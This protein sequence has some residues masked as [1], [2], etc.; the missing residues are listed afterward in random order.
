MNIQGNAFFKN[1][2]AQVNKHQFALNISDLARV[3]GVSQTQLRYWEQKNYIH[4]IKN[5]D[6]EKSTAHRYSYGTLMRVHFIKAMLDEGFTL[7][8]A[9]QKASEQSNQMEM[10]RIFVVNAFQGIE[11]RDGHHMINLGYFD[12]AHT[13]RLYCFIADGESHYRIYP[14]DEK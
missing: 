2:K 3:T 11:E 10:M 8:A 1:F 7:A 9:A 4:S 6:T 5:S 14:V 12:E 13:Q